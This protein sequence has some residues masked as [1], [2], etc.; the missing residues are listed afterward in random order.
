MAVSVTL[1]GGFSIIAWQTPSGISFQRF[2][3]DHQAVGDVT[4]IAT[5]P[6]A[7]LSAQ[8]LA[9]G[10][11]SIIWDTSAS[12]IP[13]A[14]NYNAGGVIDGS[15]YSVSTPVSADIAFTSHASTQTADILSPASTLLLDGGYVTASLGRADDNVNIP[16]VRVQRYDAA[17]TALGTD[18]EFQGALDQF[19]NPKIVP[20]ADGGY[21]V[22]FLHVSAHTSS[23]DVVRLDANGT[24]LGQT[25]PAFFSGG[26]VFPGVVTHSI[27]ALP[28]GGFVVSW[29]TSADNQMHAREYNSAAQPVSAEH[30]LG[31]AT[32]SQAATIDVFS[33]GDYV[34]SW[35]YPAGVAFATFTTSGSPSTPVDNDLIRTIAPTYVLPVGPHDVT[36]IGTGAQSVTGNMLDNII[37][38]N[39]AMSTLNGYAGNDTLIAGHNANIL[40]GGPGAD[41]FEFLYLPWNNTGRITDFA[42][43]TDKLDFSALLSAAGYSGS[44]PVADGYIRIEAS[45]T[46]TTRV[47][48]DSD[49]SASGNPWPVLVTTLD[50][51]SFAGLDAM[52]LFNPSS[53]PPNEPPPPPTGG[54]TL[55]ANNTRDQILTG[56]SAD[57]IFY[58]GH[59]SVVMTGDGGADRYVFQYLPWNNTGHITDFAVGTDRLD[60][61]ALFAAVGYTGANPVADG[62]VLFQSDGAGGS[63]VLFDADG[64]GGNPWPILV[65]TLDHVAPTSRT[66]QELF[67][68]VAPQPPSSGGQTFNGNDTRGQ[69]LTGGSGDDVFNAGHNSVVMSGDGGAN[70][71]VFQYLPWNAGHITDFAGGSDVLDLRPLFSAAHYAGMNPIADGYLRFDSD[72]ADGTKVMFDPDGPA[73]GNRWAFTIVTLDHVQ[74]SGVHTGDWLYA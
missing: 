63:R 64:P 25:A 16:V 10:G 12:S 24:V 73:T 2:T 49:G 6:T 61:T 27:A 57:D 65:T 30:V 3:S 18:Y 34:V 31:E 68:S 48:F 59:N 9:N 71:Y 21:V 5:G 15:T 66:A 14:Q 1:A 40:T 72:G 74:P 55:T 8:A 56:G 22:S 46:G 4:S 39:D 70:R 44:N 35:N 52:R 17:G 23:V 38:S 51:V 11:F 53:Q 50:N 7:W 20:M 58:T 54:Q 36:L 69:I 29:T 13:T 37:I 43:G 33:N 28:N 26:N 67:A 62:I 41:T 60:F 42:L 32:T 19:T 47:L 45:D